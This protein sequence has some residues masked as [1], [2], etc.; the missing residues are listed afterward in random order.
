MCFPKRGEFF[1]DRRK[2]NEIRQRERFKRS[3]GTRIL[4]VM[5][6]GIYFKIEW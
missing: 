1:W 4:K 2:V 5:M 3:A 6:S